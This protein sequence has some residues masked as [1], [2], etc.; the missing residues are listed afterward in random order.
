MNEEKALEDMERKIAEDGRSTS[1][2]DIYQLNETIDS[3]KQSRRILVRKYNQTMIKA[4][5]TA[6]GK[7]RL[8]SIWYQVDQL[9][10]ALGAL[11]WTI[12][13][14]SQKKGIRG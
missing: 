1:D 8:A 2:P 11:A 12:K 5:L 10:S 4:P 7:K 6:G 14:L 13:D 3:V 9:D